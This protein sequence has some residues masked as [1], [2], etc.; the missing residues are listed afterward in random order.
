MSDLHDQIRHRLDARG[1]RYTSGRRTVVETIRTA[2][3]P[4]TVAELSARM[5]VPLSSLYRTLGVLEEAEVVARHPGA[6]GTSRYEPAEWIAGHH[7]HVVCISCGAMRDVELDPDDEELLSVAA[8]RVAERA[9]YRSRGHGLE[10]E[11]IC[12]SCA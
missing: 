12:G 10:I 2:P 9:G 6:D 1:I 5:A 8:S 7:H 11:G 4:Q 3:G